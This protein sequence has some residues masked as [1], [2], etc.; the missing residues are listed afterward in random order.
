MSS[1]EEKKSS[2][3]SRAQLTPRERQRIAAKNRKRRIHRKRF[4]IFSFSFIIIAVAAGIVWAFL[5]V[6]K[7]TD[8]KVEGC[9]T[10]SA[11]LV[12]K[13]SGLKK[14]NNLFFSRLNSAEEQLEKKLPYIGNAEIT[15]LIPGTL[16]IKIT[17][18]YKVC[19]LKY[20]GSYLFL[21]RD[22]KILSREAGKAAGGL[23]LLAC[24]KP[25]N[26]NPGNIIEFTAV[27][28]G[29][30]GQEILEIYKN[31]IT[32]IETNKISPVTTVDISDPEDVSI[33]YQNRI[34]LIIGAPVKLDSRMAFAAD[35]LASENKI[36][37]TQKGEIDLTDINKAYFKPLTEN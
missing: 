25:V 28:N 22:G 35:V 2:T 15:R 5:T 19:A 32:A 26:P 7:I 17:E 10:Y 12:F 13:D 4:V 14:G 34:T 29:K 27:K 1:T 20:G 21:N 3:K 33:V 24:T 30:S 9:K 18:T 8:Y 6:F 11:E 36:S 31:L 23:P 37:K 16:K